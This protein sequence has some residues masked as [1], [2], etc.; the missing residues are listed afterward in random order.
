MIKCLTFDLDDT[1]WDIRPVIKNLDQ[2]LYQW[3]AENAPVYSAKYPLDHFEQLK[4]QVL[5][6]H[7]H[8][9]HSVTDVRIKCLELGLKTAGYSD[10]DALRLADQGFAVAL[11]ARQE[12]E[13]FPHTWAALDELKAQGYLMGAITNG[14]ADINKVG[15]QGHFDFQFSAHDAGVVKPDPLIYQQM[16]NYIQLPAHS[17]IHIGDN[18]IA[19]V[20]GAQQLGMS[21]IWVN[22]ITQTWQHDFKADQQ[23]S[24]LSD[25]PGA[26]ER[27]V[28][29]MGR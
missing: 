18:P 28:Q 15:L 4:T 19:D 16:L 11:K 7:P 1:L 3:L 22:V 13:Y 9:A 10:L 23:I 12:V 8:I 2:K 5:D 29:K 27:I 26:V 20:L 17:V 6:L 25:L 24:C 21:T 14:N